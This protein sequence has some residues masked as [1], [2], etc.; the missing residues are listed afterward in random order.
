LNNLLNSKLKQVLMQRHYSYHKT[1]LNH[2]LIYCLTGLL[3]KQKLK[4]VRSLHQY[5]LIFLNRFSR[6]NKIKQ[7]VKAKSSQFGTRQTVRI[8]HNKRKIRF[9]S[10][11][12][13]SHH[14][15]H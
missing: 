6:K 14:F 12:Q 3:L 1:F 2:C 5:F 8:Y 11:N 4:F 15:Y 7:K 13:L 10:G 9:I